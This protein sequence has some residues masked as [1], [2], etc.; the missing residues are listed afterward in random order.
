MG[1]GGRGGGGMGGGMLGMFAAAAGLVGGIIA[2]EVLV[3]PRN[4]RRELLVQSTVPQH[5]RPRCGLCR[6]KSTESTI[7]T[8]ATRSRSRGERREDHEEL[9]AVARG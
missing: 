3:S 9:Q 8:T 5:P 1:G 4:P 6:R 2:E 7:T